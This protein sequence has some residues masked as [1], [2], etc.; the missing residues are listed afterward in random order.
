[1]F[2][3]F[4]TTDEV[5]LITLEDVSEENI[6]RKELVKVVYRFEKDTNEL[7]RARAGIS[8]GFDIDKTEKEILLNDIEE[9]KFEYCYDSGD[10]DDPYL[11]KGEWSD[12]EL[13]VPR[14]VKITFLIRAKREGKPLK[15]TKTIFV[16]TGVLGKEELG[17]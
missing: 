5:I 2:A 7:I 17:L 9:F 15:F 11:W 14:G 1:M 13:R 12:D 10:E 4:G 3:F 8:L 16:P 6:S